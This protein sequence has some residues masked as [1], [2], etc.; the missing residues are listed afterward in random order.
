MIIEVGLWSGLARKVEIAEGLLQTIVTQL[1]RGGKLKNTTYPAP[2]VTNDLDGEELD[3]AWH[4]WIELES[5]RRLCLQVIQH[6]GNTSMCFLLNPVVS[7][8]EI[9]LPVCVSSGLWYA[10]TSHEW[11]EIYLSQGGEIQTTIIADY[12]DDPG[13]LNMLQNDQDL[14]QICQVFLSSTWRLSWELIQLRSMQKRTPK[15]WNKLLLASRL[16]ELLKIVQHFRLSASSRISH[17]P[18]IMMSLEGICLHLHAPIEDIQILAGIE[19]PQ[20]SRGVYPH[21]QTWATEESARHAVWHAGQVL[22]FARLLNQQRLQG[23]LAMILYQAA[24]V[25]W[26]YSLFSKKTQSSESEEAQVVL[27]ATESIILQPFIQLECGIPCITMDEADTYIRLY[28]TDG[29][30]KAVNCAMRANFGGDDR[31][32]LVEKLLQSL[33]TL[34]SPSFK[35][36]VLTS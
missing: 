35:T 12:F 3:N 7:Y 17:L 26:I 25:L 27:D 5:F 34:R 36:H 31:P 11:K 13:L 18:D 29:V 24:L 23:H 14:R 16:D 22:R 10:A 6:D 9:E 8:A 1:R 20:Q 4:E 32:F 30:L 33:V 21:I 28:D 15:K 19:G 2:V